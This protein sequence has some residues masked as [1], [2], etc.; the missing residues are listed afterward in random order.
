VARE[1]RI[2]GIDA[3]AVLPGSGRQGRRAPLG[4]AGEAAAL[5][6]VLTAVRDGVSGS[7]VLRGPAGIGKTTLLDWVAG[8]ADD[9]RVARVAGVE[10]E[11]DLAF[12]GLH[13]LLVPFLDGMERLPDPQCRALGLAFGMSVGSA[14]DRFLVSLAKLTLIT[15]AASWP[16]EQIAAELECS[17][18]RARSRGGWASGAA[19]LERSA[20]LT[21]S[22]PQ[23]ARR[24]LEAAEARFVAGEAPAVLNLGS[25]ET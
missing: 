23:Q 22:A 8:Q 1:V 12:A 3:A 18:D 5:D 14:P 15:E 24:L 17:A 6:R 16:D 25:A 13:Q 21:P 4:R 10:S 7:L 19:F 9:M 2:D 11:M 20:E